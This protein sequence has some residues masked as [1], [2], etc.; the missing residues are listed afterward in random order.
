MSESFSI[1]KAA[2]RAMVE[3]FWRS[4]IAVAKNNAKI[5]GEIIEQFEERIQSTAALMP[6]EQAKLFLDVIDEE[7]E[8]LF[9]EYKRNPVALK[10][11]LGLLPN[12]TPVASPALVYQRQGLG[13]IAVRTAVRATIWESVFSLFRLFR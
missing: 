7:R 4:F 10:H 13:E 8:I 11:R 12:A 9:N 6:S 2:V 3:D 1:D 5:G